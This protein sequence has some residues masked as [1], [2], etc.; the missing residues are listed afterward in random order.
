M[1]EKKARNKSYLNL[2]II[3]GAILVF[4]LIGQLTGQMELFL[5]ILQAIA[6]VLIGITILVTIHELGHFLTAKMFGMRVETFSIGFP[7]KIFSFTKGETE[8]QLGATPLGGFVKISGIIDESLDTDHLNREP[9]PYEFRA[10]PVWQRLIV[11]TGGV[12]MNVILGIFVFSMLFYKYGETRLPMEQVQY[13]ILVAE[14]GMRVNKEDD[15]KLDTLETIYHYIG[16]R[17]G[18]ELLSFKGESFDY[19]D[20]YLDNKLLVEDDAWFEVRR[21]GETVRINVP[22]TIQN[23]FDGEHLIVEP[24]MPDQPAIVIVEDSLTIDGKATANPAYLS[25][26]RSQDEIIAL[27][28]TEIPRYSS[29]MEY[30]KDKPNQDVTVTVKRDGQII[31]IQARTNKDSKLGVYADRLSVFHMDTVDYAFF[32]SFG[33]GTSKAFGF[34]SANA[35]GIKNLGRK[36]VDASKSVM[37]PIQIAKFY[38]LRFKQGGIKAFLELTAMLSMILAL[39]NILPIPALDGG[40]VLFLL[41]EAV[42]RREPS[43]KVRII[44]QQIGMVFILGLM[45]L[46]I[47]N[48][49]LR[50][51]S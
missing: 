39:V 19:F 32:E 18:D 21:N 26:L 16:F 8:Y 4:L 10:K 3:G 45:V 6:L 30:L 9:E 2:A 50:L 14:N 35:Q 29:L 43:P 36:G 37:G 34:L 17:T 40:H 47:G 49:V 46:I 48:D 28:S 41:I 44:A 33:V 1:S 13:G 38:L 24:I 5:D 31:P 23:E 22:D 25:G 12:I 51:F 11:M 15:S 42:T 7:P 20:D 27:D